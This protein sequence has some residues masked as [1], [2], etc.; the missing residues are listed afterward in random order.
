MNYKI[1]SDSS[2]NIFN[3]PDTNYSTVPL[4]IISDSRE[5]VDSP[6]LDISDMI[7]HFKKSKEKSTT[8]CPNAWE[9]EQEFSDADNVFAITITSS[10]SGSYSSALQAKESFNDNRNIHIIDS[11][12]T[13]PEMYLI[14]EKLKECIH[15]NLSFDEIC[16]IIDDYKEHTHLIFSLESLSN[17]VRNGRVSPA[18]AAIAGILGIRVVGQASDTGTLQPLKKCRGKKK[19]FITIL[20]EMKAM[21]FNGGNVKIAHCLNEE[22]AQAMRKI[23][24]SEFQNCNI[25][26]NIC[27]GLCSYYAEEG[28]LL[29]GFE[30][31]NA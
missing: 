6:D 5:F 24:T 26:I 10:L 29:I 25:E 30:D 20:S 31:S 21:G 23:I 15:K 12:S 22:S 27:T 8:S 18:V 7:E 1:V 16:K 19:A 14:I 11:L 2:S 13:G 3:L 17:L 9:W 4:K 28:G